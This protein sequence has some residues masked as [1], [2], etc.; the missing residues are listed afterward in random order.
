MNRMEE[1]NTRKAEIRNLLDSEQDVDLDALEKELRELDAEQQKIE[2]RAAIAA[3]IQ[4]GT[5]PSEKIEAPKDEARA[6][7]LRAF[8]KNY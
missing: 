5:I 2:K 8:L 1:I 6:A 7:K 4:Q 3:G